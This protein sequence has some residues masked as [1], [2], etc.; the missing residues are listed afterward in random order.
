M[1]HVLNIPR[2]L[3][4]SPRSGPTP[5]GKFDAFRQISRPLQF[6]LLREDCSFRRVRK[7]EILQVRIRH[8]G[9]WIE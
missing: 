2:T 5:S 6:F 4:S 9:T 8:S 3:D 1:P 7:L